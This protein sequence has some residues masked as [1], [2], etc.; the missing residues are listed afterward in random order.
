MKS[1]ALRIWMVMV[2]WALACGA[3]LAQPPGGAGPGGD[4]GRGGPGFGAH[5]G[6]PPG[7]PTPGMRGPRR[8]ALEQIGLSDAQWKKVDDLEDE[9]MRRVIRLQADAR[10][11]EL[12]LE[13]TL[14]GD[15]PDARAAE[16]IADRIA[17]FHA[18]ILKAHLATRIALRGV[19]TPEQQAKLRRMRETPP[20]REPGGGR[21]RG[22]GAGGR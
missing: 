9:E 10:I 18:A 6:P 2:L 12:D 13:R 3:A 4:G 21:T 7:G 15:K 22:G 11:A 19:L 8:E 20:A 1:T 16:E 17:G 5:F 14:D